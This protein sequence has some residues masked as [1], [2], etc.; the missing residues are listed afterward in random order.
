MKIKSRKNFV[1]FYVFFT[2]IMLALGKYIKILNMG[3]SLNI[4]TTPISKSI[5]KQNSGSRYIPLKKY[6]IVIDPGHG[7]ID[8]GTSYGNMYEKDL[9]LKIARY[10]AS[11]L[12]SKGNVVFLTRNKDKLL[13]LDQIGDKVNSSCADVFVSIHIN[14]LN[15][16]NFNGITTLY[17]DVDGYQKDERIKLAKSV[18]GEAVKNDNWENRGIKRQN[19]AVLRY[20][21][22][23]GVLVEC[24]FITNSQ[25]RARLSREDVLKRLGENISNGVIS[26][27]NES[28][29][30]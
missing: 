27:L 28:E 29:I 30:N 12:R 22:I 26:Y 17:Y 18:E 6:Y 3:N 13:G 23:P 21:K 15:D 9:T 8:K 19:L 10:A 24:G 11:Y 2:L 5:Y 4:T 7:G 16:K 14:S 1:L 20:S 25:D